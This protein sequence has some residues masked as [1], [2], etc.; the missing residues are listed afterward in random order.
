MIQQAHY[1]A[2]LLLSFFLISYLLLYCLHFFLLSLRLGLVALS[3]ALLGREPVP[4]VSG[5]GGPV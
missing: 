5:Q 1:L 3:R 4:T 2:Y